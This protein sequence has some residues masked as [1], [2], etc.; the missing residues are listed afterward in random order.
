MTHHTLGEVFARTNLYTDGVLYAIVHLPHANLSS[1]LATL[2]AGADPFTAVLIDKD[3][4]TLV[5]PSDRAS[6]LPPDHA[7]EIS[8]GRRLITFDVV[9]EHDLIGFMATVSTELAGDGISIFALSAYER[10]HILVRQAQFPAAWS[11]LS[12]LCSPKRP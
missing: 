1:A 7:N 9:L 3:E 8:P 10:D 11:R 5:L 6:D 2:S 4:V 12:A